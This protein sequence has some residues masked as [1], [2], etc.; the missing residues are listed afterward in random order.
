MPSLEPGTELGGW[1]I[2]D[3]LGK[4]G[5]GEVFRVRH[6]D[7]RVGALKVLLDK[8]PEGINYKRFV[9]EVATLRRLGDRRGLLPLL[10]AN[11]PEEPAKGERVWYVMPEA[12][13][14][15]DAMSGRPVAEVVA[16]VRALAKTL[17]ELH[18][19]DDLAHR[20]VKPPNLYWWKDEPA[21]GDFGLVELPDEE[22]ITEPGRVPGAFGYIP[23]ELMQDPTH[24][25]K[26]ADVFALAKV[27]WVLLTP[28]APY[29]PQGSLRADGGPSS[30]AR[31][32]TV[33]RADELD[34]ILEAATRHVATRISMS[35]LEHELGVW[36]TAPPSVLVPEELGAAIERARHAMRPALEDR[37]A[38]VLRERQMNE[39]GEHLVNGVE[40]LAQT[41]RMVDR[42]AVVGPLAIGSM[43]QLIEHE[44][45][46]G[47]PEFEE[48][49]HWGA[50]LTRG[51]A[52]L[53]L[54]LVVAFC[55]QSDTEGNAY[56]NGLAMAGRERVLG[57]G[58]YTE[59]GRRTAPLGSVELERAID[60]V[61]QEARDALPA[62]LTAFA[63]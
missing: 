44:R 19:S 7:D 55:L 1:V 51:D 4:G 50:R 18:D 27:L 25:G 22:S 17:A 48:T 56:L 16:A 6:T 58:T 63:E 52:P 40:D 21:V 11:V 41:L 42:D 9:R 57:G 54:V 13:P 36:L 29:P 31:T 10:D 37:D 5:N 14:L 26:P 8:R 33:E 2:A 20:D 28:D 60:E 38:A 3:Y 46:L 49:F 61:V 45:Y 24:E 53:E 43:H 47:G 59:L 35:E 30:L 12:E 15:R 23:D 39:A 34:R 62:A 32:L